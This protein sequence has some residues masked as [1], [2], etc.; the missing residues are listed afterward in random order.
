MERSLDSLV[1]TF[2]SVHSFL[3]ARWGAVLSI[4]GYTTAISSSPKGL[5]L[6]L[7]YLVAGAILRLNPCF[8]PKS[9]RGS[10]MIRAMRLDVFCLLF[11]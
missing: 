8:V 11:N 7:R 5:A 6:D 4:K 10:Y 1:C 2:M 9:M 3:F